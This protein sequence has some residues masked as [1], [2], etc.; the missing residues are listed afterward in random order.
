M[1]VPY[2]ASSSTRGKLTATVGTLMRKLG[3]MQTYQDKGGKCE[4]GIEDV[5]SAD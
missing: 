3:K 2:S 5:T 4:N 1:A